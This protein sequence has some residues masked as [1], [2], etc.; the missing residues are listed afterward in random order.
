MQIPTNG[1]SQLPGTSCLAVE[2]LLLSSDLADLI[3]TWKLATN[4]TTSA[5]AA[6]VKILNDA[7]YQIY[8]VWIQNVAELLYLFYSIFGY[9]NITS[10]TNIER[11]RTDPF[12]VTA[13]VLIQELS[14]LIYYPDPFPWLKVV[15][16]VPCCIPGSPAS[17]KPDSSLQT[18]KKLQKRTDSY[19]DLV[20]QGLWFSCL[21]VFESFSW[22]L[23]GK[24]TSSQHVFTLRQSWRKQRQNSSTHTNECIN[25]S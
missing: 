16:Q 7:S 3:W 22:H 9:V 24:G 18:L 2:F 20:K 19:F 14:E 12:V 8:P 4:L 5:T 23:L 13:L 10:C 6:C 11:N 21:Q 15:G 17:L 25:K 1:R